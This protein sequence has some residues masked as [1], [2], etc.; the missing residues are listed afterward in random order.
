VP[1]V[2]I[3][4]YA[5]KNKGNLSF[6]DVSQRWGIDQPS[7]SNGAAFADL[8]NDGDLDY[9][10]NNINDKAFLYENTLYT[11][12]APAGASHYLRIRLKG[13][14]GN[15]QGLGTKVTLHYEQGKKQYHDHSVYRGYLSTVENVI[16]FG[17]G[18]SA[19]VDTLIVQWPDKRMQFIRH[20][21]ADQVLEIDYADATSVAISQSGSGKDKLLNDVTREAQVRFRHEE[22]DFI[23]FNVQRTLPHK[24]SQSGPGIAVGDVTGDGLEDFVVA[25]HK[26]V[27]QSCLSKNPVE[28]SRPH[29]S[30]NLPVTWRR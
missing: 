4:N 14:E 5:F 25:G 19:Q 1:V 8:D 13:K 23:D 30:L 11:S 12:S 21:K 2:K 3:P 10:V 24:F 9:V 20:V 17:L 18:E 15:R 6:A 7:F 16:H 29:P 27:T 28:H 22:E 26:N